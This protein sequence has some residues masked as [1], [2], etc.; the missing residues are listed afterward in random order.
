MKRI[1]E[2]NGPFWRKRKTTGLPLPSSFSSD[3]FF[4]KAFLEHP[5]P[6]SSWHSPASL[7]SLPGLYHLTHYKCPISLLI[8]CLF[9]LE[10]TPYHCRDFSQL[11]SGGVLRSSHLRLRGIALTVSV[12]AGTFLPL[13]LS[14]HSLRFT[15]FLSLSQI[16]LDF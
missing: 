4:S 5:T 3:V 16:H 8:V 7:I 9:T 13:F 11:S 14:L 15:V 10:Y 2:T 1:K 6:P 12:I